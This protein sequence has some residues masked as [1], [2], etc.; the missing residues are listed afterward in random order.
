MS[1]LW[2]PS[3]GDA[4]EVGQKLKH[5]WSVVGLGCQSQVLGWRKGM[6]LQWEEALGDFWVVAATCEDELGLP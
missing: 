5:H 2:C 6:E 4:H 1:L 3:R